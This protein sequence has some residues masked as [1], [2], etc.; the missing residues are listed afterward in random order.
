[1]VL[2]PPCHQNG[3]SNPFYG[4]EKYPKRSRMLHIPYTRVP[5]R[6]WTRWWRKRAFLSDTLPLL[7]PPP[8]LGRRREAIRASHDAHLLPR[9]L[10]STIPLVAR[11]SRPV[12]PGGSIWSRWTSPSLVGK[13]LSLLPS[14]D[15]VYNAAE[16]KEQK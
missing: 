9:R 2:R 3:L 16:D 4:L 12:K 10:R 14:T 8:R 7:L 1:M 13:F 11:W 15:R 6:W 5:G